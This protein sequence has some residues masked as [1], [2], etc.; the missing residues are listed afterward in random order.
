MKAR[1]L[2]RYWYDEYLPRAGHVPPGRSANLSRLEVINDVKAYFG[3]DFAVRFD[4]QKSKNIFVMNQ[5]RFWASIRRKVLQAIREQGLELHDTDD[6]H[7]AAAAARAALR[8]AEPQ[9]VV[10]KGYVIAGVKTLLTQ[11]SE[12][13]STVAW[14]TNPDMDQNVLNPQSDDGLAMSDVLAMRTAYAAG[15]FDELERIVIKYWSQIGT[16]QKEVSRAKFNLYREKERG[17]QQEELQK[18]AASLRTGLAPPTDPAE[19]KLKE[20]EEME[21][22]LRSKDPLKPTKRAQELGRMRDQLWLK[23]KKQ[24]EAK[25]KSEREKTVEKD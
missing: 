14:I 19:Q 15:R 16:W 7:S 12:I 13:D 21:M 5:E 1:P 6:S 9:I 8:A 4:L 11:L 23:N 24:L 20:G 22:E 2:Q 18:Q 10:E 17:K 25:E 3:K